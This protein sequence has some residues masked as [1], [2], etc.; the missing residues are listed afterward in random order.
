MSGAIDERE[1]IGERDI[2][3]TVMRVL[4]WLC[5]GGSRDVE[6]TRVGRNSSRGVV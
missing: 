2:G 1:E 6:Y 5:R 3:I 4:W